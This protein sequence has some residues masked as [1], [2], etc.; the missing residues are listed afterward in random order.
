M[1]LFLGSILGILASI[2]ATL[3]IEYYRSPRL[4]IELVDDDKYDKE[5]KSHFLHLKLVNEAAWTENIRWLSWISRYPAS[6]CRGTITFH[7]YGEKDKNIRLRWVETPEPNVREPWRFILPLPIDVLPGRGE[8]FDVAL[9]YSNDSNQCYA[10]T[11][12]SYLSNHREKL[13]LEQGCYHIDVTII[14]TNAKCTSTF[15]LINEKE[16]FR[17]EKLHKDSSIDKLNRKVSRKKNKKMIGKVIIIATI[18]LGIIAGIL[19]ISSIEAM[20]W[21]IQIIQIGCIIVITVIG[22]IITYK[23]FPKE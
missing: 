9:R 10:W 16:E 13:K 1:E 19:G 18:W 6:Q 21:L 14:S 11:V 7:R 15:L 20:S 2:I 12:E 4:K 23:I 3:I 8:R 22:S 5:R 17:I